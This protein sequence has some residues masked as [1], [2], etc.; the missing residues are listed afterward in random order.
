VSSAKGVRTIR[1]K[2]PVRKHASC[3]VEYDKGELYYDR[4][5]RVIRK[6]AEADP[7]WLREG[8]VTPTQTRVMNPSEG[9]VFI[10]SPNGAVVQASTEGDPLGIED[11]RVVRAAGIAGSALGVV[12]DE[13]ELKHFQRVEYREHYSFACSSVEDTEEWLKSLGLVRPVDA[14]YEAFGRH[15]AMG[16]AVMTVGPDC[17]YRIE[18]RGVER[19]AGIPV[20]DGEVTVKQSRAKYLK[21]SELLRLMEARRHRQTDPE[22]AVVLDVT[23]FLWGDL[24]A[25]FDLRGFAAARAA[26]NLELFRQCLPK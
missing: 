3:A 10:L 18:L 19:S 11:D 16:W 26:S 24:D 6:L 9:L 12:A 8:L 21:R 17:R 15:Y 25:D 14:L 23:A 1:G 7:G 13:L 22:F 2:E 4:T 20:G 5:G